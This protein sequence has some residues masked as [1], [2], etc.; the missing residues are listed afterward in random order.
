MHFATIF[1]LLL[2]TGAIAA[3]VVVHRTGQPYGVTAGCHGAHGYHSADEGTRT[4]QNFN[5]HEHQ[6]A[7]GPISQPQEATPIRASQG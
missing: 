5:R 7:D 6:A 3:I 4:G 1:M 2:I